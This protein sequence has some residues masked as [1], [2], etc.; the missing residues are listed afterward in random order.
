MRGGG[1]LTRFPCRARSPGVVVFVVM[2]LS[3]PKASSWCVAEPSAFV[4]QQSGQFNED[5]L[6]VLFAGCMGLC[7]R[8]HRLTRVSHVPNNVPL[9]SFEPLYLYVPVEPVLLHV[10][11]RRPHSSPMRPFHVRLRILSN[12]PGVGW[13]PCK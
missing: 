7:G 2:L 13:L 11:P 9:L 10:C 8:F 4:A 3:C 1:H 5:Y 6:T 12:G